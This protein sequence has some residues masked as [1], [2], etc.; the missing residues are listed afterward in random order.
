MT[1]LLAGLAAVGASA[2]YIASRWYRAHGR[3]AVASAVLLTCTPFFA[4]LEGQI[5][6]GPKLRTISTEIVMDASRQD[7]WDQIATTTTLRE[8][9]HW[10]FRWGA[11]YPM[12]IDVEGEG[13]GSW[14][15]DEFPTGVY[16]LVVT[17]WDEPERMAFSVAAQPIPLNNINPFHGELRQPRLEEGVYSK[18]GEFH[19][20]ETDDGVVVRATSW[21]YNAMVPNFYWGGIV[22]RIIQQMHLLILEDIEEGLEERRAA[23]A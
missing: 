22:D 10:F 5:Q 1:P 9:D 15:L 6:S 23:E 8:P 13:V 4:G 21:Y 14:R 7:I 20:R 18:R 2:A 17:E 11:G 16:E 19:L 12:H 3:A